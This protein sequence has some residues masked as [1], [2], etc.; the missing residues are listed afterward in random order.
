MGIRGLTGA[1][2][3]CCLRCDKTLMTHHMSSSET[4]GQFADPKLIVKRVQ[5]AK[6]SPL[7]QKQ[8]SLA[9]ECGH[10]KWVTSKSRPSRKT[11]ECEPCK[12]NLRSQKAKDPCTGCGEVHDVS[13]KCWTF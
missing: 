5:S 10:E 4:C 8:W 7:N 2:A 13:Q 11:A 6:V 12:V 3:T 9:L 1:A